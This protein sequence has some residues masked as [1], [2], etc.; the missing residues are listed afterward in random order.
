MSLSLFGLLCVAVAIALTAALAFAVFAYEYRAIALRP[1]PRHGVTLLVFGAYASDAG[2][3]KALQHRL[4]HGIRLWQTGLEEGLM[5]DIAVSGGY[6]EGIDETTAMT[7]YLQ[8]SGVDRRVIK[9]IRPGHNT[10]ATIQAI[11]MAPA[12]ASNP[13]QWIA[14]SSGYHALRIRMWAWA[15]GLRL[16]VSCPGWQPR[17]H[18]HRWRQRL[19]EVAALFSIAPAIIATKLSMQQRVDGQ[20]LFD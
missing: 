12:S 16:H 8:Q 2:L 4:N 20:E 9:E 10:R 13:T 3:S 18:A 6:S 19:R 15:Y 14:I 17:L 7:A 11:A 1:Q 5:A